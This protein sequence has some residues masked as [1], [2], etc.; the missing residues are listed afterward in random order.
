MEGELHP[1][2]DRLRGGLAHGRQLQ[3]VN[4]ISGMATSRGSNVDIM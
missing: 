1:T 2:K 4:L 3:R